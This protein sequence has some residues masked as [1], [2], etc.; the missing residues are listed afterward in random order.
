MRNFS[1]LNGVI[2][3]SGLY[4]A[5]NA[6]ATV[7]GTLINYSDEPTVVEGNIN[8]TFDRSAMVEIP[9]GFDLY[10]V[11]IYNPGSYALAY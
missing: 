10:R 3:A 8:F 6:S 9:A 7:N 11:P 1:A 5:W 2:A 4:F